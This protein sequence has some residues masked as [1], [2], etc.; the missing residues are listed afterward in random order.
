MEVT[1]E[2]APRDSRTRT[3]RDSCACALLWLAE[4]FWNTPKSSWLASLDETCFIEAGVS[5]QTVFELWEPARCADDENIRSIA[6][7]YTLLFASSNPDAPH[8]YES[9]FVSEQHLLMQRARDQ[10]L[11][12]YRGYGYDPQKSGS[13]EP[14]DHIALELGFLAFLLERR[15]GLNDDI[16]KPV[17][18]SVALGFILEHID[19]WVPAFCAKVKAQATTDFYKAIS[20][21]LLDVIVKLKDCLSVEADRTRQQNQQAPSRKR[22]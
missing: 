19:T 16:E 6:V 21:S 9:V 1:E 17:D 4:A 12:Y 10:V 11:A 7:D 14:D 3:V 5:P 13:N 15:E 8:P 2:K 20:A 22:D 18:A